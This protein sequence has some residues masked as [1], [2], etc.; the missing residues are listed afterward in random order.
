MR[1]F[2]F[3]TALLKTRLQYPA[4]SRELELSFVEHSPQQVRKL[5]LQSRQ[6][7][8]HHQLV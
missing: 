2:E 1:A 4:E 7:L 8:A 6:L 3:Y 5:A